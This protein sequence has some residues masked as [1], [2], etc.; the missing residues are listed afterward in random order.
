[1][2]KVKGVSFLRSKKKRRGTTRRSRG[3]EQPHFK[4]NFQTKEKIN[5]TGVN[6][7]II[8]PTSMSE[9]L[10]THKEAEELYNSLK[11]FLNK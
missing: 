7:Q 2:G 4:T 10:I 5:F 8:G 3:V 1:M 6:I 11:T 9:N